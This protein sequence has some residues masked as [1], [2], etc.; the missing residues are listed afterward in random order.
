MRLVTLASSKTPLF[1]RLRALR[2]A[3]GRKQQREVLLEEEDAVRAA[4][5]SG[6][7][8][9]ALVATDTWLQQAPD[10]LADYA[11]TVQQVS[12][13][14]MHKLFPTGRTPGVVC[15]LPWLEQPLSDAPACQRLLVLEH[16]QDGGNL[17]TILRTAAGLG[18]RD[19]VLLE[20]DVT[21]L[22]NRVAVRASMGAMFR[23]RLWSA[24]LTGL[25]RY[26]EQHGV[27][28]LCTT[29]RGDIELSPRAGAWALAVGNET[30]GASADLLERSD[31]A[32]RIEM[33]ADTESLNVAVATGIALYAL[34]A[35]HP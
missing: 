5:Q 16:I 18:V 3:D 7:D 13:G 27:A 6:R 24:D 17:G 26:C 11:G 28:L 21:D 32:L 20:S 14:L 9:T 25:A 1:K 2:T 19:V 35:S 12:G 15:A 34:T 4:L 22:Y 23:L 31:V 33:A 30:Q 8:P 10:W 29:P